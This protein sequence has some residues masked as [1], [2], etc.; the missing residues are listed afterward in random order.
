MKHEVVSTAQLMSAVMKTR[1]DYAR[2]FFDI[3]R[4]RKLMWKESEA[5]H[6]MIRLVQ[7]RQLRLQ[8][9]RAAIKLIAWLARCECR[10][11]WKEVI[12][13]DG[14]PEGHQYAELTIYWS[15]TFEMISIPADKWLA[16]GGYVKD[17]D[18]AHDLPGAGHHSVGG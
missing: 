3:E 11:D 4:V 16:D 5:G 17:G 2:G 1:E 9:T 7:D 13:R 15:K 12:P 8:G 6:E 10:I 18:G 14:D